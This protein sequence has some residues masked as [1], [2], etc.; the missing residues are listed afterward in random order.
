MNQGLI[1]HPGQEGS[2][3]IGVDDVRELIALPGGALDVHMKGLTSLLMA[4]LEVPWVPRVLVRAWKFS[5][6][7]SFKS[8][9]L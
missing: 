3:H 6:K 4:V 2:Y 1:G 7:I 5:T 9:Q 8:A